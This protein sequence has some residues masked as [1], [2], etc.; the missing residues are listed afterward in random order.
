M[1]RRIVDIALLATVLAGGRPAGVA[2]QGTSATP[3]ASRPRLV[4]VIAVDQL[5]AEQ[6]DRFR[7][8]FG[9]GGFKLFLDR[10]ARFTSARYEHAVTETCPGHAVILTGSYPMVNGIVA[11]DWYDARRGRV[12]YCAEDSTVALTGAT[13]PGRSPRNLIGATVGDLLKVATGGRS[14]VITV[15]AKDRAAIMLGGKLADVAYWIVDSAFVTSTYYR[16]DLPAWARTYNGTR[17]LS[18]HIGSRWERLLPAAAYAAVGP[19]D[20]P[21][22]ADIAGMGRTF[23]H[24]IA[25]RDAFDHSP[26][27]DEVVA[28][29]AMRAV[30]AER[31]GR[32]TVP[33]LLGVSFSATDRVGHTFGPD[34][35]EI[36]DDIVRLDRTL[37]RLF[38]F[39]DRSVGL[40]NVVMV[41]TADHG[42][43]PMPELMA[44]GRARSGPRRMRPAVVDS[45]V[46][47]ALLER[48]GPAPASGW[49][50]Y[51]GAPLLFL[52]RA[53][54]AAR[55]TGLAEAVAVAR[56]AI[57]ELPGMS[58]ALSGQELERLRAAAMVSGPASDAVRSYYPG[59]GGDLY[60]FLE[61]YWLV[62]EEPA[63]TG[64]GSAWAYDQQVPLLWF[65]RGIVAGVHRGPAAVADI[66]PTLSALLGLTA[67]GGAQGRVL[68]EVLH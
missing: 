53:A 42:V 38:A 66:A 40:A 62:T 9:T 22:E 10:G 20:V 2:A 36:M 68:G 3:A 44:G 5:R 32:D 48:F 49:V 18:R 4:V 16:P 31:L 13:G 64:H 59:R 46:N 24:P 30:S 14:R 34:S 41:L 1:T 43:A 39:L 61:P 55:R 12:V 29:F 45:A 60:Y 25:N 56:S 58:D 26:F 35:H 65:G 7:P 23:P 6:L 54:L 51:N 19:D 21:Y 37:A 33:D 15:S 8:Y 47:R 67:P 27:L 57:L 28:D 52:S 50:A 11:N 17:A 63:G